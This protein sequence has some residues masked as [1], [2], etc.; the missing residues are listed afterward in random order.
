MFWA[1]DVPW[2]IDPTVVGTSIALGLTLPV[3]ASLPAIRRGLRVDLRQA[4]DARGADLG[5][6]GRVDRAVR[7]I[8]GLPRPAQLGLRNVGRRK[9]R[10]VATAT[11]VALA[12]GN[13]LAVMALTVAATEATQAAWADHLEDIQVWSAGGEVF[14]ARAERIIATTPGVAQVEPVLKRN[15]ELGGR[16]A[17]IWAVEADPLFRFLLADGRWFSADEERSE[18]RVAVIERN[19]AELSGVEL[20]DQVTVRTAAGP[21][22]LSVIGIS[23]NQQEDG[24]ALFVPLETARSLLG[25]TGGSGTFWV[26]TSASRDAALVDRTATEWRTGWRPPATRWA[27]RSATSPSATRWR[28]TATSPP[29]SPC[30]VSSW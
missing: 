8:G 25:E 28:R 24:L 1:I 15:V 3:L 20:G 27:P 14:D 17:S 19:L 5:P 7:H 26:S 18:A 4:L 30:S 12:V 21:V 6:H 2:G 23:A 13:L 22:Q 11:I 9:R 16:D 10:T 29:R